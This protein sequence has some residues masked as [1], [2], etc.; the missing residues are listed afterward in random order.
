M[1]TLVVCRYAWPLSQR[2]AD[3]ECEGGVEDAGRVEF[4]DPVHRVR[5]IEGAEVEGSAV[6]DSLVAGDGV[7][8]AEGWEE[9]HEGLEE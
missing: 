4:A 6:D 2:L 5:A 1:S 8:G 3:V 9:D 7:G